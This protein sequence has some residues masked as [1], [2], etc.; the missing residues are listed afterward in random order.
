MHILREDEQ[1][2]KV[3]VKVK[4]TCKQ[5]DET[6]SWHRPT[7]PFHNYFHNENES[8]QRV[9]HKNKDDIT[10]MYLLC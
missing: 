3:R 1:N 10:Y 5:K 8:A 9:S 6:V 2:R 4:R 7:Q